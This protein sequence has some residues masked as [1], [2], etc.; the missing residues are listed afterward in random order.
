MQRSLRGSAWI[1]ALGV[2]AASLAGCDTDQTTSRTPAS[3]APGAPAG[4]PMSG[5][6]APS[7]TLPRGAVPPAP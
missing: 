4:G 5:A 7:T 6:G 2:L 1:I 3:E